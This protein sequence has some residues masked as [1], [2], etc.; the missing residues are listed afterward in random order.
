MVSPGSFGLTTWFLIFFSPS[1]SFSFFCST[2]KAISSTPFW[3]EMSVG[4]SSQNSG[5]WTVVWV[6]S[7][8][9]RL[10]ADTAQGGGGQGAKQLM[11]RWRI[12]RLWDRGA[13]SPSGSRERSGGGSDETGPRGDRCLVFV[14]APPGLLAVT[15][16]PWSSVRKGL[17]SSQGPDMAFGFSYREFLVMP[18]CSLF[19]T[20]LEGSISIC[21]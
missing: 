15:V 5:M 3:P 7:S 16:F 14:G 12:G 9:C 4:R 10:D 2:S 18:H 6:S 20:A 17:E 19:G 21:G 8:G 11:K 1:F 13:S